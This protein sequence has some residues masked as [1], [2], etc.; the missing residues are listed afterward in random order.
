MSRK[1]DAVAAKALTWVKPGK[2]KADSGDKASEQVEDPGKLSV[3]RDYTQF[4]L[5]LLTMFLFFSTFVFQNFKIPT[6]SMENNLLIGDHITLNSMIFSSSGSA[7]DRALLPTREPKRGDV[8][9]FKFP[10]DSTQRWV[11]R[12][13]GLPGERV[14]I[15]DDQVYVD[16]EPIDERYAF[17]KTQLYEGG[18]SDRDPENRNL[19][20][21][22]DDHE[23]GLDNAV[24]RKNQNMD[25][26]QL[27]LL[28]RHTLRQMEQVYPNADPKYLAGLKARLD[29]FDGR[30]IPEGFYLVMG[31]NRNRSADCR[32][33]GLLPEEL[34][35]GR[36]YWVWWSYGEE[37]G[38][39]K[40]SG[41][42]FALVY[43]RVFV[44]A[45]THTHW[46]KCFTRIK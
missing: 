10:L 23:P 40:A 30:T 33:W 5:W 26:R 17:F 41:L 45:W 42:N 21:G 29:A 14:A 13:I 34:V 9:V 38:T 25:I 16:G 28:T 12:L 2:G 11:K 46:D 43:L 7:L 37:E 22:Y 24:F 44:T 31:D 20:V 19:P 18:P 39:H 3:P 36:P 4:G 8:V 1:R 27:V 35:E 6:S 15:I 32:V